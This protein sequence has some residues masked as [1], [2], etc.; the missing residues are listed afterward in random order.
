M[1]I[2]VG[3]DFLGL[4]VQRD[5]N[6]SMG[7]ILNGY[8]VTSVFNCHKHPPVNHASQFTLH[9]LKPAGTGTVSESC[10]LQLVLFTTEWSVSCGRQWHFQKPV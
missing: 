7:P 6:I 8:G 1:D 10:N 5:F 3:D 4:Y 9:N 2:P